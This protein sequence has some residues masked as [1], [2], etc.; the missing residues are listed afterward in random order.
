M[1]KRIVLCFAKVK[2]SSFF[3]FQSCMASASSAPSG[4]NWL[5][6][7]LELRLDTYKNT[8][9]SQILPVVKPQWQAKD[10]DF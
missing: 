2:F 3:F 10:L 1:A 5:Y 9:Y 4:Y 8:F 7:P 6:L